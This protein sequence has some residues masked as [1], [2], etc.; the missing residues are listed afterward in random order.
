MGAAATN[1]PEGAAGLGGGD[2]GWRS[3]AH[4]PASPPGP[5]SVRPPCTGRGEHCTGAPNPANASDFPR[6]I[7]WTYLYSAALHTGLPRTALPTA[8][9]VLPPQATWHLAPSACLCP[10]RPPSLTPGCASHSP[11]LTHVIAF[12]A[13][14]VWCPPLLRVSL[15]LSTIVTCSLPPSP[16]LLLFGP[17]AAF[18]LLHACSWLTHPSGSLQ[19]PAWSAGPNPNAASPVHVPQPSRGVSHIPEESPH[20]SL[21]SDSGANPPQQSLGNFSSSNF[22]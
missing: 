7:V 10:Q 2:G 3:R 18:Q 17:P 21:L 9:A 20:P 15:S 22:P 13:A 6:C 19:P 1:R 14:S 16:N 11:A 4:C 8:P 12:S 5:V